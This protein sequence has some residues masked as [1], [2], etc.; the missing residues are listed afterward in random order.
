M[1]K[2]RNQAGEEALIT[3]W[4]TDGQVLGDV[5]RQSIDAK[6]STA[7]ILLRGMPYLRLNG[8]GSRPGDSQ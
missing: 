2:L 7:I 8:E 3:H 5:D 1:T 6:R 4:M